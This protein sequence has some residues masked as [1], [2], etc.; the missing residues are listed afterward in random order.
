[1]AT[2]ALYSSAGSLVLRRVEGLRL[3]VFAPALVARGLRALGC[4][5]GSAATTSSITG[6][7]W[8]APAARQ[9]PPAGLPP[10][11]LR[12][13]QRGSGGLGPDLVPSLVQGLIQ[14]PVAPQPQPQRQRAW[15]A[16]LWRRLR[17]GIRAKPLCDR[18]AGA[19][20]LRV[21]PDGED[22]AGRETPTAHRWPSGRP[23]KLPNLPEIER[24]IGRLLKMAG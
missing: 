23:Q 8:R 24:A 11:R 9:F 14:A 3:A 5:A 13:F 15:Q 6:D 19:A 10:P 20:S 2:H 4:G 7:R 18:D 17:R 21:V 22:Q 16:R 12:R 1:M